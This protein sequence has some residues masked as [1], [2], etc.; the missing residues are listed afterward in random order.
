[1]LTPL[2]AGA[3]PSLR[4][5]CRR[6]KEEEKDGNR[7]RTVRRDRRWQGMADW[8]GMRVM[9]WWEDNRQCKRTHRG[10][11]L[12]GEQRMEDGQVLTHRPRHGLCAGSTDGTCS[13]GMVGRRWLPLSRPHRLVGDGNRC[14]CNQG[15]AEWAGER[16]RRWWAMERKEWTTR[17][18]AGLAEREIGERA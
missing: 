1:M 9:A 10:R 13:A 17:L 15:A 2:E 11:G 3:F 16:Q 4:A 12:V 8:D 7:G 5:G 14:K 18:V 6:G